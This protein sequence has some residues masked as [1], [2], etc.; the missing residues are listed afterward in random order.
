[1]TDVEEFKELFEKFELEYYENN[2]AGKKIFDAIY[3]AFRVEMLKLTNVYVRFLMLRNLIAEFPNNT[4]EPLS[5]DDLK[6]INNLV[7]GIDYIADCIENLL[8][9]ICE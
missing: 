8:S 1:M 4:T 5:Q 6:L 3:E 2:F 7:E 9:L